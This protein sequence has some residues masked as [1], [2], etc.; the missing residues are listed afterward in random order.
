MFDIWAKTIY[1]LLLDINEDLKNLLII[2]DDQ[3]MTQDALL[4]DIEDVT[5]WEIFLLHL[6]QDSNKIFCSFL[7]HYSG[8][9]VRGL[10][11]LPQWL[12]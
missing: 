2:R 7:Y 5:K 9:N 10:L 11:E 3:Y 12:D 8:N 4:V 1:K 6:F